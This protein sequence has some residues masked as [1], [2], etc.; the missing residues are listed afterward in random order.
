VLF[1]SN[2]AIYPNIYKG[3]EFLEIPF[4]E[5]CAAITKNHYLSFNSNLTTNK[6]SEFV[7]IVNPERVLA[8]NASMHIEELFK[9]NLVDT[10]LTNLKLLQDH[11]FNI[12]T[13]VVA[14]PSLA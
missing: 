12:Y 14:H 11:G 9:R 7:K 3:F 5:L 4:N 2:I 6:Y 8:S 13:Q 10:Y 1:F